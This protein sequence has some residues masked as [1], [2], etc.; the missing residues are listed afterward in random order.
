MLLLLR[1]ALKVSDASLNPNRFSFV[2]PRYRISLIPE[3]AEWVPPFYSI[4]IAQFWSPL[5]PAH[6]SITPDVCGWWIRYGWAPS[7]IIASVQWRS[8]IFSFKF[9]IHECV[10][11]AAL[12]WAEG[13]STDRWMDV[14]LESFTKPVISTQA[15]RVVPVTSS[16]LSQ[17]GHKSLYSIST[18]T[19]ITPRDRWWLM[20]RHLF[21]AI[22]KRYLA[23]SWATALKTS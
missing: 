9:K 7:V 16:V 1:T 19:A 2:N 20:M 15:L 13:W 23:G 21:A 4:A 11:S 14:V 8:S 10:A 6:K 3:Y 22:Y 18:A 12:A 5:P 17:G